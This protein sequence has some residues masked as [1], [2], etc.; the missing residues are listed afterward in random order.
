MFLHE[1]WNSNSTT[2]KVWLKDAT[3]VSFPESLTVSFILYD[4]LFLV[5][6]LAKLNK[7]LYCRVGI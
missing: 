6:L 5:G 4:V 2:L 3:C 1:Q 7:M